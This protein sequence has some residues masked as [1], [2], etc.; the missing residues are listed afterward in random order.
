MKIGDLI[1]YTDEMYLTRLDSWGMVVK[2]DE[3]WEGNEIVP[4]RV[5]VLWDSGDI[6][7]IFSDEAMI[8]HETR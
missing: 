5:D 1:A 8:I 7:T 2:M 6:E 4:S 3:I